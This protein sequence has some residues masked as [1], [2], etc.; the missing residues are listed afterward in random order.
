MLRVAK[1]VEIA[2][3][4]VEAV[5]VVDAKSGHL[6][7]GYQFQLLAVALAE[8][9]RQ[10]HAQSGELVDVEEAPVIDL[11]IAD[12]P[13]SD[14][15]RLLR[16]NPVE[17]IEAARILPVAVDHAHGL[18]HC[19]FDGAVLEIRL[20]DALLDPPFSRRRMAICCGSAAV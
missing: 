15:V 20:P 8:D 18:I 9:F 4:I 5:H 10:L 7:R 19:L 16:Q 6:A 17:Q 3:G 13:V 14:A 1:P 2:Q 11:L 12:L